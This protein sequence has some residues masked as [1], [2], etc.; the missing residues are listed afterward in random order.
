M[1]VLAVDI[2]GTNTVYGFIN[3]KGE[4]IH[5]GQIPTNGDKPIYNLLDRLEKHLNNFLDANS[6]AYPSF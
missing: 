1:K 2:G 4:I 6:R 3:R 5:Y